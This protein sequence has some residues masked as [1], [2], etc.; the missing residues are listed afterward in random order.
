[1]WRDDPASSSCAT[2]PNTRANDERPCSRRGGMTDSFASAIG[3][4]HLGNIALVDGRVTLFDCIEF[5]AAMRWGD[6]MSDVAFLV[7]DLRER[8]R[9]DLAARFANVYLEAA[10]DY[11]GLA[12]LPFYIVYRA[13]VRAKVA[14]IQHRTAVFQKYLAL[15]IHETTSGH[16]AVIITHGVT[17]SG[18]TV[19]SQAMLESMGAVRVRSDV[20]RKRLFGMEANARSQSS[21]HEGLST[22]K[23]SGRTYAR[24]ASLARTIA[25]AGYPVVADAAFLK[26]A[27]RDLLRAVAS[28]LAVPFVIADCTAP[29]AVLRER[30]AQRLTRGGDASEATLA[31]LERQLATDEPLTAEELELRQ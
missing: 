27:Q 7:M 19:R 30:V 3:D 16:P 15:A 1:M 12:V 29:E 23:A 25:G 17:G 24:L 11:D 18:K 22:D 13:V 4:L 8:N 10:N 6:V 31:V 28:D 14:L 5:N 2:G 21:L 26:R 20:E 9:P